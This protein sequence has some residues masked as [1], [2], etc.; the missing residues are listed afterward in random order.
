LNLQ[1]SG[2]RLVVWSRTAANCEPLRSEGAEVADNAAMV[3]EHADIIV[4]M[5]FDESA[6]DAVLQR[7]S[8]AFPTM[9]ARRT[10]VNMSSVAPGY[11]REL[12]R[13]V[14]AGG[15]RSVEAPVSGSRVPAE[16]GQSL[17]M[18][19]GEPAVCDH[20]RP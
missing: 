15:G 11:S 8:P 2:Q 14:L 4:M 3:F 17:A 12:A 16:N 10:I 5:L 1:R 7:G 19:A 13:D 6:T 18:L 9:V 20:A